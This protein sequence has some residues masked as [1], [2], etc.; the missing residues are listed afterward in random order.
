MSEKGSLENTVEGFR[1]C[2]VNTMTPVSISG[3]RDAQLEVEG[4]RYPID[5]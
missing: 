4:V 5:V 2:F 1:F 3:K